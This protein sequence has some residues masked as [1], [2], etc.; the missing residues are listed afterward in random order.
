MN[1]EISHPSPRSPPKL[2]IILKCYALG[3]LKAVGAL[4]FGGPRKRH[5]S[6]FVPNI[7]FDIR[8]GRPHILAYKSSYKRVLTAFP[9]HKSE[10][11]HIVENIE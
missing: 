7:L 4:Q 9:G 5:T 8:P 2:V 11:R 3:C 1:V 10:I 6:Y